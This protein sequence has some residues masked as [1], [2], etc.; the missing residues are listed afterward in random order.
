MEFSHAAFDLTVALVVISGLM[1]VLE[2]T[3]M[4]RL[5]TMDFLHHGGMWGDL[6]IL[7]VV[8]GYIAPHLTKNSATIYGLSAAAV[9]LTLVAHWAWAKGMRE[10]HITG[11]MF[12][13]HVY[14]VWYKDLSL[15]GW[16]HVVTMSFLLGILLVYVVSPMPRNGVKGTF[17]LVFL[18]SV[19]ANGRG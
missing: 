19:V 11:H 13:A 8:N 1:S 10:H 16:M 7:S 3:F 5:V 4:S 9:A 12:P 15:S 14:S 2:R 17:V 6:L 18:S